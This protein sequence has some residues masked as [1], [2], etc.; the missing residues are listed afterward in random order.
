MRNPI[1]ALVTLLAG[2]SCVAAV[3]TF[4]RH[5]TVQHLE[6]HPYYAI[7]GDTIAVGV[8]PHIRLARIDAPELPGHC[9]PGRR[10]VQGDPYA[11]K[12]EL[13]RLLL[14]GDM[15]CADVTIDVYQRRIA[16]CSINNLN[17]SDAMLASGLVGLYHRSK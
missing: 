3:L 8:G 2:V 16:E 4:D 12:A 10:C 14:T 9:R 17:L 6:T 1:P 15:H 7:D 11:A 13:A 5:I